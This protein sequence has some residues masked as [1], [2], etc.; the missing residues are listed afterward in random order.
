MIPSREGRANLCRPRDEMAQVAQSL[1]RL[2][3]GLPRQRRV[4]ATGA[5]L[6]RHGDQLARPAT[7]LS[8]DGTSLLRRR[9]V[10]ASGAKSCRHGDQLAQPSA[11]SS[12]DWRKFAETT[13]SLCK[14]RK[15]VPPRRSIWRNLD[16][17]AQAAQGLLVN[18]FY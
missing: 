12:S 18:G 14:R 11:R 15:V 10:C 5:K 13:Q 3:E 9:N 6:C 7:S 17:L 4:C 1:P 8:A 16:Q 2:E